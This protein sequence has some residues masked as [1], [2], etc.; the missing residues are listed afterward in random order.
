MVG[1]RLLLLVVIAAVPAVPRVADACLVVGDTPFTRTR[2]PNET[3]PPGA[4]SVGNVEVRVFLSEDEDEGCSNV[5][6]SPCGSHAVLGF[7]VAATDDVTPAG[8]IGYRLVVL[9]G[10][11]PPATLAKA[12]LYDR[13]ASSRIRVLYSPLDGEEFDFFLGVSAIDESGNVGPQ[14]AV[15]FAQAAGGGCQSGRR[16]QPLAGLGLAALTLGLATRRRR[17][18]RTCRARPR[19]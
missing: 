8:M 10:G 19:C 7:S 16:A 1:R 12:D 11:D 3:A 4:V 5:Q 15:R 18:A 13:L 9:P 6:T 2:T 14:T 17:R